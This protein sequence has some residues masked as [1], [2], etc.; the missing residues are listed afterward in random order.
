[1]D[2]GRNITSALDGI[3]DTYTYTLCHWTKPF[4]AKCTNADTETSTLYMIQ[5]NSLVVLLL[6]G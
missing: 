5:T 1:M 2:W 6:N 3:S 4:W